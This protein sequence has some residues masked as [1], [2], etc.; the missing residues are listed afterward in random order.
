MAVVYDIDKVPEPIYDG[1]KG[2]DNADVIKERRNYYHDCT[3]WYRALAY[4]K[5][6]DKATAVKELTELKEHGKVDELVNRATALL[7]QLEQ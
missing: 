2:A 3:H 1:G 6:G 4:L 7:K 5:G